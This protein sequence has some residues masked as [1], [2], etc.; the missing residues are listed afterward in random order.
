MKEA[1][2]EDFYKELWFRKRNSG[3][4][5]WKGRPLKDMP[6]EELLKAFAE[7]KRED[8]AGDYWLNNGD[9]KWI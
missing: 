6:D 9:S 1:R 7:W 3:R 2:E 8:L 5:V 4:L